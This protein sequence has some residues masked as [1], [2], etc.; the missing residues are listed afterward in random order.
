VNGICR[1]VGLIRDGLSE[2]SA[3]RHAY[4]IFIPQC[5]LII[6]S[7]VRGLIFSRVFADLHQILIG[8]LGLP[9]L[10]LQG[11][12]NT[13]LAYVALGNNVHVESCHFF[14]QLGTL[15]HCLLVGLST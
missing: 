12:L 14:L 6:H 9:G 4:P 13:H 3:F 7:K 1:V 5:A 10:F 8:L 2:I 15:R 11:R